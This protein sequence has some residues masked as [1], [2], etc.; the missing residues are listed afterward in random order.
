MKYFAVILLVIASLGL[1]A[2]ELDTQRGTAVF[3]L[4]AQYRALLQKSDNRSGI[5]S[6][7]GKLQS[8]KVTE[9]KPYFQVS[10]AKGDAYGLS[11]IYQVSSELP[12]QALVNLLS[13]DEHVQYAEVIYPDEAFAVPNDA[14]YAASLYFAA[15]EAEAAWDIHKGEDGAGVIVAVVDTGSRWTHPDLAENIWNN[16]GEDANSNGYTI[17]YNGSTW[18]MDSGDLNG[19]DD[20]ANGKIDDLIGW[21]FMLNS[22]GAEANNPYESS[23]HGTSVSGI[24]CARTNN[25]IGVSSLG[26]NLTLMPISCDY[27]TGSIF[28]GYQGIIYAAENGADVVNCSWGSS[29][30]SQANQDAINYAYSLGIIIVAAAGNSNNATP[31]YPSAYQNVLATAALTNA[32]VKSSVS[33]YGAHVDVAAPNTDVGTTSGA[34]YAQVSGATSYASPIASSLVGLVKSYYPLLTQAEIIARIKGSCDDVDALNPGKENLLGE[35][36]LNARR[37]LAD[38][39]PL[40]DSEVRLALVENRGATDANGNRA[41]EPGESFSVNLLLRNN[42]SGPAN[43]N[44]VLSSTNPVVSIINANHSAVLPADGYCSL[45]N[46]FVVQVSPLAT[47]Q[48]VTFTLTTTADIPLVTGTTLSFSILIHAGGI[49]VWEG[50][51]SARDM[52]GAFIRTTLQGLGYTVTYGTTF[53]TSFYNF[54]AV[55]LSFGAVGSNIVRFNSTAMFD[56]LR[57]YLLAGGRVYIEGVDVV[58]YDMATYLPDIEGSLDAHE[59]LWP[60]L[61]IATGADGSTNAI[62]SLLGQSGT[63]TSGI[64]FSASTQ[65]KVD[66]IDTFTAAEANAAIVF[67]ESGYGD[68]AV[69]SEG[70]YEQ[71]S[72]VFSYALRELTDG[73][74]P[75]TRAN[76]IEQIMNFFESETFFGDLEVPELSIVSSADSVTVSWNAVPN[77]DYYNLFASDVPDDWTAIIPVMVNGLE[78]SSAAVNKKFFRVVAVKN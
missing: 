55:F 4:K 41:V 38:V 14:N 63:P 32:G 71:R 13:A 3:K 49:Y 22:A 72:F 16:L 15:L 76:L 65:T 42:G 47:S 74:F 8:L 9:M 7:D 27:G 18:V 21:D 61:G 67:T 53:P 56:A 46:V 48:Y 64:N 34:A 6:L 35:G 25:L 30:Y 1:A 45:E 60:L 20:D 52:S 68:V 12:P 2:K 37:A 5:A 62:D 77:A 75:H 54:E 58:A 29:A 70:A 78:Y 33:S 40:P 39:D 44:F 10:A 59:I 17:Y 19:I 23:G 36:K 51:A 24:A 50:I 57:E 28:K 31:I 73:V 26:W 43:A 66:F 11:L 69:A